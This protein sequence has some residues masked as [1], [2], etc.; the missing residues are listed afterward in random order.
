MTEKF[1]ALAKN[2]TWSLVPFAKNTNVID[3]KWV[4]RIKKDVNGNVTRYKAR[5]VARKAST[6]NRVLTTKRHSVPLSKQQQ[7]VLFY[8]LL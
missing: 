4:H 1:D 2:G 6:N 7:S 8:L 3:S 5:L